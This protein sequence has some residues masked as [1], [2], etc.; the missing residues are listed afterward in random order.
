MDFNRI[1]AI[2]RKEQQKDSLQHLDAEFYQEAGDLLAELYGER[3]EIAEEVD[4]PFSSHE[5]QQ[6]TDTIETIEE[7]VEALYERRMGKIVKAASFEAA[8]M[9]VDID[10]TTVEEK[11]LFDAMVGDL[12]TNRERVL[13]TIEQARTQNEPGGEPEEHGESNANPE[14]DCGGEGGQDPVHEPGKDEDS[15]PGVPPEEDSIVSS[16]V[17]DDVPRMT[18]QIMTDIGE[19]FGV[20]EREYDLQE[21]DVV[22]LPEQNASV[23]VEKDAAKA[24][25]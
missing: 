11:E 15:T 18:V 9:A 3:E 5:I 24:L 23:L 2:H 25:H 19:I 7:T 10:A 4:D 8:G 1:Q 12:E 17:S 20:D 6:L 16:A 22:T 14:P 21:D 13:T